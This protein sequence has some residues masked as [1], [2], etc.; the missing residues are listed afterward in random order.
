MKKKLVAFAVTA[1][2]VITSAVPALAWQATGLDT[3]ANE[4]VV[5]AASGAAGVTDEN[6]A[7]TIQN[8]K[9]FKTWI[10]FNRTDVNSE[11][12]ET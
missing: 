12:G 3:S 1:A 10:D 2:M 9:E 7:G 8:G 6:V 4:V 5:T 11:Y